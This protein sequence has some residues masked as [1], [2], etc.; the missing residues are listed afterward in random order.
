M[1]GSADNPKRV[2]T[3][4]TVLSFRI[5]AGTKHQFLNRVDFYSAAGI[6]IQSCYRRWIKLFTSYGFI[7]YIN[8]NCPGKISFNSGISCQHEWKTERPIK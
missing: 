1:C 5:R 4:H 8:M 2:D 7:A 6:A 3:R